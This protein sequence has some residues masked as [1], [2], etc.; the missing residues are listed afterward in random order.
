MRPASGS[1]NRAEK[2]RLGGASK[3]SIPR[4][5]FHTDK[6]SNHRENIT[7]KTLS[8]CNN[9]LENIKSKRK[10]ERKRENYRRHGTIY[11]TVS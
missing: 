5:T 10:K 9:K 8:T 2:R 1:L 3:K 11:M 7:S 6:R 4:C